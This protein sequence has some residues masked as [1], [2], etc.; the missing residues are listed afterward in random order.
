MT[1][2]G[3]KTMDICIVYILFIQSQEKNAPENNIFLEIAPSPASGPICRP[4]GLPPP[5]RN[6][7]LFT[8]DIISH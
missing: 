2:A 8:S 6:L 1:E 5:P 3:K 4:Y 7:A